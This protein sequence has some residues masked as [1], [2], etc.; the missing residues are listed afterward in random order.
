MSDVEK[1]MLLIDALRKEIEDYS[2]NLGL[3]NDKTLRKIFQLLEL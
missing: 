1:D 3:K 2:N